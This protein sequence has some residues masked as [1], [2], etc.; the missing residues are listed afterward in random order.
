ME[1]KDYVRYVGVLIESTLTWKYHISHIASKIKNTV[2]IIAH[3]RHF[4]PT[5]T[6]LT[7]YRCLI[8]PHLSYGINAWGHAA[9]TYTKKLTILQKRV[10]HVIYFEQYSSHTVPL[11]LSADILPFN[12]LYLK[13]VSNLMHDISNNLAPSNI[14]SLFIAS[15]QV[16]KHK[17]RSSAKGN[18]YVKYS[19]LN[20]QK[21]LIFSFSFKGWIQ[22]R[23]KKLPGKTHVKINTPQDSYVAGMVVAVV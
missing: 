2:G 16:H 22:E 5:E 3:L 13:S 6:L 10:M 4:V 19:R 9:K 23:K 21:K 14:N 20:K 12:M 18:Y 17:T 8:L 1:H 11:F 15:D 7:I